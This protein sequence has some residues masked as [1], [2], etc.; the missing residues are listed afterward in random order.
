M[1]FTLM[2]FSFMLSYRFFDVYATHADKKSA[3]GKL[4]IRLAFLFFCAGSV[5][6]IGILDLY[7]NFGYYDEL[8]EALILLVG[9]APVARYIFYFK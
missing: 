5:F 1:F 8:I 7:F 3:A 6:F 2:T 4:E 9:Y